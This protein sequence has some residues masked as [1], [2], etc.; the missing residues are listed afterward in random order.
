MPITCTSKMSTFVNWCGHLADTRI[1]CVLHLSLGCRSWGGRGDA[2]AA[3]GCKRRVRT[4]G[5]RLVNAWESRGRR[6]A[7]WWGWARP[8]GWRLPQVTLQTA[9]RGRIG[10]LLVHLVEMLDVNLELRECTRKE[11][12]LLW[13]KVSLYPWKEEY[14]SEMT[15]MAGTRS[16]ESGCH[17][18]L[19]RLSS[20]FSSLREHPQVWVM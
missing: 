10:E 5:E 14:P 9:L 17:L 1:S 15:F 7:G 20:S 3:A 18:I 4:K 8:W 2:W 6:W 11:Q 16:P 19:S 13:L 12:V